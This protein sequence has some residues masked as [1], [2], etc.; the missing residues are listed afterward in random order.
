M[1]R[2]TAYAFKYFNHFVLLYCVTWECV[3]A[4][5]ILH[6]VHDI[7]VENEIAYVWWN[8]IR[9]YNVCSISTIDLTHAIVESS[10]MLFI[11]DIQQ[12]WDNNSIMYK[13]ELLEHLSARDIAC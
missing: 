4:E 13:I 1:M 2:G 9:Y 3:H 7:G 12:M 5:S 11:E 8:L 6:G 10:R